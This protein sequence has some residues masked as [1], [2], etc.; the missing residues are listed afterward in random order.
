MVLYI[1]KLFLNLSLDEKANVITHGIGLLLAILAAPWLIITAFQPQLILGLGIFMFGMIFMFTSSTLYHLANKDVRKN[2]WR[3]VDHISIFI[4]IGST[5]TPFILYYY[6]T[7][8]GLK[9][10]LL[11]WV[12]IA[13]GIIFKLVYKTKYELISV[14]LYL[15]L[16]WM[17]IF[18]YDDITISMSPTV[19]FWLIALS[20]ASR[21]MAYFCDWRLLFTLCCTILILKSN[22]T[23]FF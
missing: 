16:G 20:L 21:Y 17:V 12:I 23:G 14:C 4:L 3:I 2:R 5:Y 6:N 7:S 11:H 19:H 22:D 13:L 1:K 9:F 18:I 8:V 15:V 10:L